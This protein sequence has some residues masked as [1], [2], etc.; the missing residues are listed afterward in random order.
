MYTDLEHAL[1]LAEQ[2]QQSLH[3]CQ[4]DVDNLSMLNVSIGQLEDL[5]SYLTEQKKRARTFTQP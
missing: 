1:I 5:K 4:H 3:Q 2:L